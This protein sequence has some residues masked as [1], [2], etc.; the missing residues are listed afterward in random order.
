[1][2][3]VNL[4]PD[5]LSARQSRRL[6]LRRAGVALALSVAAVAG[7]AGL[8]T[9]RRVRLGEMDQEYVQ[10][11]Q[12]RQTL[13]DEVKRVAMAT[14]E[15]RTRLARADSLRAKRR[16]SVMLALVARSLPARCWLSSVATDPARP[17]REPSALLASAGSKPA[18]Q[19][20]IDS[21]RKLRLVG[22]AESENDTY[23]LVDRLKSAGV[24]SQV[25]LTGQN[26]QTVQDRSVYRFEVICSW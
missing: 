1:M 5:S 23:A 26:R 21:P 18:K 17:G 4:I 20:Q 9:L 6:H 3:S 15:S 2:V 14:E 24:F 22:F 25:E 8:D 10:L 12:R 19:V 13:A 16:W 7:A 11:Q